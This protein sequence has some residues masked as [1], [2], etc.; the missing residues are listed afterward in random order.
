LMLNAIG[1]TAWAIDL[2]PEIDPGAICG[3]MSLL[4]GSIMVLTGKSIRK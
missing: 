3:A 1:Q 4:F 2:A